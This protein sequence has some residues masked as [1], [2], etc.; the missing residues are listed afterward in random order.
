MQKPILLILLFFG[1][2]TIVSAQSKSNNQ[3]AI[4]EQTICNKWIFSDVI[5]PKLS[6]KEL[7]ENKSL[8]EGIFIEIR[9]DKTCLTS[10][11]LELEGTWALDLIKK[12]IIIKDERDTISWK[13]HSLT[14]NEIQLSRNDAKQ[15]LVFKA[16]N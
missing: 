16:S 14:K 4:N 3:I 7:A 10:I 12:C 13:I 6:K 5:N 15:I 2:N 9:K 11:V 1:I 8:F